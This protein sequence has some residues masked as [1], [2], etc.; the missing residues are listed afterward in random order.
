M[1]ASTRSPLDKIP[2]NTIQYKSR[3]FDCHFGFEKSNGNEFFSNQSKQMTLFIARLL[4]L[5]QKSLFFGKT[6]RLRQNLFGY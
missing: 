2:Y 5:N 6:S 3:S 1:D 4:E